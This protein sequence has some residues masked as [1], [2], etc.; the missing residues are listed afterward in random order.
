MNQIFDFRAH[1]KK[2]AASLRFPRFYNSDRVKMSKLTLPF[3]MAQPCF[4][5]VKKFFFFTG[6]FTPL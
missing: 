5:K 6:V 2:P 1:L 3:L 4:Y